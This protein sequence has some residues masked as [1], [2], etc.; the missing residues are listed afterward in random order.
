MLSNEQVKQLI[1]ENE[2]LQ[3]ELEELNYMLLQREQ[4]IAALKTNNAADTELRSLLDLQLDDLQVMQ[5]RIGKH[6]RKEAGAEEREF[7]LHQ[8]LT[9]AVKLQHQYNDLFQQYTYVNTQLEDIQQELAKVKKRNN[10]L[11]QIA[12]KIGEMES[13]LEN[14]TMERDELITKVAE[15]EKLLAS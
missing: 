12:V 14:V 6:Q 11:Q 15:L 13:T 8:E 9:Q 1:T 4:T 2:H 10:M 5:N 7:E 3:V